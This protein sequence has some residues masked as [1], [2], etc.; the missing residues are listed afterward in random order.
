[1]IKG[2]EYK[3]EIEQLYKDGLS[4][5]KVADTIAYR[6]NMVEF[7][8]ST[9]KLILKKHGVKIRGKRSGKLFFN[10]NDGVE[11]KIGKPGELSYKKPHIWTNPKDRK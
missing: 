7:S 5:T 4:L 11:S 1:M 9:V 2:E 8:G 3:D 6:H 10:R